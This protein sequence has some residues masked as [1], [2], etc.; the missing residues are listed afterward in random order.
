[1]GPEMANTGPAGLAGC[2]QAEEGEEEPALD[3]L[4]DLAFSPGLPMN[5]AI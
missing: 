4:A 2:R 1:M 5:E 3:Y